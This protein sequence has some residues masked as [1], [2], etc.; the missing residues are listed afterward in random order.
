[1]C[2]PDSDELRKKIM[3]EAHTAPYAM[4]HSSTKLYQ[5][6]KP[7]YWWPVMKRDIVEYVVRCLTCQQV[8]AEHQ[9]PAR[10]LHP[11]VIPE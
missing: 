3:N 6:L 7:F 11:L 8:K 9:A 1:M 2:V 10:K 4:H 5:D